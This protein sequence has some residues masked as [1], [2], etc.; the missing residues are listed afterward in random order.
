MKPLNPH[1][2]FWLEATTDEVQLWFDRLKEQDEAAISLGD[3]P[4]VRTYILPLIKP[5]Q[6]KGDRTFLEEIVNADGP[7]EA[8]L[9][10]VAGKVF[11]FVISHPKPRQTARSNK[12]IMIP[13]IVSEGVLRL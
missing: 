8:R 5:L 1:E 12:A 11:G 2:I 3:L 10:L 6:L 9:F 13:M 4:D 7:R